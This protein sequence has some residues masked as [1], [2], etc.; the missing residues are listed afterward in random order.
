[1]LVP[2]SVICLSRATALWLT[3]TRK[4]HVTPSY[5]AAKSLI[6][7]CT[8]FHSPNPN[9]ECDTSEY[10][11]VESARMIVG[12]LVAGGNNLSHVWVDEIPA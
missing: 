3:W 11:I 8:V 9:I 1:M 5:T 10:H 4:M 7:A 6:S 2:L 12:Q